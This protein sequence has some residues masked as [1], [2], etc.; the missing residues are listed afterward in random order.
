MNRSRSATHSAGRLRSAV[1]TASS[2]PHPLLADA[3]AGKPPELVHL[4]A[5]C[6]HLGVVQ[7]ARG[8]TRDLESGFCVDDNARA[9]IVAVDALDLDSKNARAHRIGEAALALLERTQLGDGS[10][11]NMLD[12]V[13]ERI[14][15][16]GLSDAASGR[17]L[18]ALGIVV[19]RASDGSWRSRAGALLKNSWNCARRLKTFRP[20]A[21]A[22]LGAAAAA[23]VSPQAKRVVD[24]LGATLLDAYQ[25][26]ATP[27]WEWWEPVLTWG[28][29][30]LPEA[31][32]RAAPVADSRHPFEASGL[33]ALNFLA[34]ITQED[35]VFVPIGNDGWYQRGS[36]R[37]RHDQQPIEAAGMVDAWLAAAERTGDDHYW[38]QALAA[39]AWFL[40]VNTERLIVADLQ[41]GGCHDGL[42]PGWRNRNMGAESTL[43]YLQAHCAIA[44]YAR[45]K[46]ARS[47]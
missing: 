1:Q 44:R 36:K 30:R 32:L 10:F 40:G 16:N 9:L 6:H 11:H 41:T 29:A 43:S 5:L 34:S 22:L 46:A 2:A 4:D 20:Q 18:W 35:G 28:N 12:A 33:R 21:Y 13:G 37:A 19:A 27:Q 45:G 42:G 25:R 23:P 14:E 24:D 26:S 3:L 47:A 17:A 31:M 7:F 15:E 38:E 8:D 39:F